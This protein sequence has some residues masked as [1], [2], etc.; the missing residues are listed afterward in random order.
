MSKPLLING[1]RLWNTLM[2]HGRIGGTAKGGVCRLALSELDGQGRDLFVHWCKEAGLEVRID[3]IGN[4]FARR[5][6]TDPSRPV[7]AMGSHIDTQP[8]GGKFDGIYG[9]MAGLE[10]LRTLNDKGIQTK[11]PIEVIAW[12]NEEGSRFVPVMMGSGVFTG[13]FTLEHA[14]A[15]TDVDGLAVQDELRKIGYA[16]EVSPGQVPGGM[17]GAYF[18]A[19]IE[20]GPVL[21]AHELTIGVVPGALGQRWYDVVVTGQES[22]AGTTPMDLRHDALLAASRI[23][24]KVNALGRHFAPYGRGT[25]GYMQVLPNS[26]NTIPGTVKFS[27]DI[28]ALDDGDL[29]AME[30]DLKD[31]IAGLQKAD[32]RLQV[33]M[34]QVVYF[35]PCHFDE[36][37][38]ESVRAAAQ[39][40]GLGHMDVV[41]GAG[42]DAVY[43][44]DVAPA[45]MIFVPCKDGISHNEAEDATPEHLAAGAHVLLNAVLKHA[46]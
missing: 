15:A 42:H 31:F 41:S 22:H 11:A 35:P 46:S 38:I 27:V 36:A 44:A 25:V 4:I 18:E 19:H 5:E 2:E 8:T 23:V 26:R 40:L 45:G 17:F 29:L 1:E 39:A 20:Q 43:V 24:E 21:E 16:G 33:D 28:R 3:A 12:T 34:K 7:I 14:L 9:V 13:A 10:V 37:C 30:A 6:G 32:A